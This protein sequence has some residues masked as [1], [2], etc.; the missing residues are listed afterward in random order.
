MEEPRITMIVKDD[1]NL[2]L[3]GICMGNDVKYGGRQ[4]LERISILAATKE[5]T[6]CRLSGQDQDAPWGGRASHEESTT[7]RVFTQVGRLQRLQG[8]VTEPP[9]NLTTC[10]KKTVALMEEPRIAMIAKDDFNLH[11]GGMRMEIDAKYGRR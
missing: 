6:E 11:L 5:D 9:P 4:W 8:E 2:L 1:F 10:R 3:G 7:T